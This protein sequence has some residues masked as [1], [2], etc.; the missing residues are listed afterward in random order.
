MNEQSAKSILLWGS[1]WSR[2]LCWEL[3][4]AGFLPQE[5]DR[6][7]DL[8]AQG[9]YAVVLGAAGYR[10]ADDPYATLP[11]GCCPL[12]VVVEVCSRFPIDPVRHRLS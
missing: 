6:L 11:K 7:F 2:R 1:S 12:E 9:Y 8:P 4:A 10:A 3:T 5:Y